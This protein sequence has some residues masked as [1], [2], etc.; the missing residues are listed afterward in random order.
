MPFLTSMYEEFLQSMPGIVLRI[1]E[2][3]G[4]K[5]RQTAGFFLLRLSVSRVLSSTV[6]YLAVP[7]P[8]RSSDIH[9]RRQASSLCGQRPNLAPDGVYTARRVAAAPVSSYLPFPSLQNT[10]RSVSV[11]LS[12][13]S[14]S[15][16]V[17]RR[18]ALW[19]SD[20]PHGITPRDRIANSGTYYYIRSGRRC[21]PNSETFFRRNFCKT[22]VILRKSIY[23]SK[24]KIF[25]RRHKS[26]EKD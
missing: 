18:P 1:T 22:L 26:D 6:I 4:K 16:D 19:C 5:A 21:Q 20:F 10:L 14:P 7:L 15:P 11:A 8:V 23:N 3:Y 17:I 12:L 13:K 24:R 9:G 2:K 25:F